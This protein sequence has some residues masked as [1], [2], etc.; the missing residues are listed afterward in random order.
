M[1][2]SA[3]ATNSAGLVSTQ[4]SRIDTTSE[5]SKESGP[6]AFKLS[7]FCTTVVNLITS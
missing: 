1:R 7:D 3:V 6:T 4:M 5:I 2:Q